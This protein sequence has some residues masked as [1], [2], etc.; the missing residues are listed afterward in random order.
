[1]IVD[2]EELV[3]ILDHT[4]ACRGTM[5]QD[6]ADVNILSLLLLN[7]QADASESVCALRCV[8]V[9]VCVHRLGIT[10]LS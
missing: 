1:M 7:E 9:C 8:C 2:A 5:R 4:A 3:V 10:F 6:T